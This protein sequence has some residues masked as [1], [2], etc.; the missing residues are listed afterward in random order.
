MNAPASA[1]LETERLRLR[2]LERRDLPALLAYRNDPEVARY[3]GWGD[4]FSAEQGA[5]ML[6]AQTGL[7]PGTPGA[8]FRWMME[9]KATAAVVGDVAMC[10]AAE[11]T[12]QAELGFTLAR[13]HQGRGLAA[14][15]VRAV[16]GWAFGELALHR[17]VA[18]TDA[19]NDAA[20]ALLQRIGFR[21]EAHFIQNVWYKGAWGDEFLFAMLRSEWR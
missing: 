2:R 3:Q 12:R 15:A 21:R 17:V 4:G 1:L 9:E 8:W 7:E 16:L 18:V 19:R 20:A 13:E 11:D 5:A 6:E 10:V 14:E